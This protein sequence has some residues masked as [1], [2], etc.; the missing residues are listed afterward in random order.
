MIRRLS[1]TGWLICINAA[2]YLLVFVLHPEVR[3]IGLSAQWD[4]LF[5]RPWT[6]LSYMF[7]HYSIWHLL[8]NLVWLWMFGKVLELTMR[9][10]YV[11]CIYLA[12]GIAGAVFYVAA[13]N[14]MHA[15]GVL[16][17][18][19]AAVTAIMVAAGLRS[20][21]LE[22]NLLFGGR[23]KLKW[24]VI[25]GVALIFIG[26]GGGGFLAHVGGMAAGVSVVLFMR[27]GLLYRIKKSVSDMSAY[28]RGARMNRRL[29]SAIEERKRNMERFDA[30]LDRVRVSGFDSLSTSEK[31]QLQYLSR[32]L[33]ANKEIDTKE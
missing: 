17:G 22:L 28:R 4:V 30:L 23:I 18:A 8:V 14:L 7:V 6:I 10:P 20:P 12:G 16:C 2:I 19:S 26:A 29:R 31:E 32:I 15:G 25:I 1:A 13:G 21:D 9:D 5:Q 11:W 33:T 27:H 3:W 24:I